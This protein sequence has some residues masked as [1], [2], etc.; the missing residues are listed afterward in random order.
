MLIVEPNQM[1]TLNLPQV[2]TLNLAKVS[3]WKGVDE[4]SLSAILPLIYLASYLSC[5]PYASLTFIFVWGSGV[6]SW[7]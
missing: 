7:P 6:F 2:S 5:N 1:S 3:H 4:T